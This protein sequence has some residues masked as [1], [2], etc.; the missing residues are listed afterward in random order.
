VT[1]TKQVAPAAVMAWLLGALIC[2]GSAGAAESALRVGPFIQS[3][4]G[5][6]ATVLWFGDAGEPGTVRYGLAA[7]RLD[8][9]ARSVVRPMP[10]DARP[11]VRFAH[12]AAL[13]G[14][15]AGKDVYYRV[16]DPEDPRGVARF[17]SDPGPKGTITFV[18]GG[19][20]VYLDPYLPFLKARG[21]RLDMALDLGDYQSKGARYGRPWW[22]EVPAYMAW[23]NHNEPD[24]E[25]HG[26]ALPGDKVSYTF[27]LGP[28]F[29]AMTA[30]A[31]PGGEQAAWKIAAE[32]YE[33]ISN[34]KQANNTEA[35][36]RFAAAGYALR[37]NGNDHSCARTYPVDG[38]RRDPEGTVF[39]THG[40]YHERTKVVNPNIST[41]YIYNAESVSLLPIITVSPERLEVRVRMHRAGEFLPKS[42][43]PEDWPAG[44]GAPRDYPHEWD[45][46]V[47]VKNPAYADRMLETLRAA[48]KA[49]RAD[50]KT[51]AAVRELGG[52]V[53]SR[54]VAPLVELLKMAKGARLRRE[55]AFALDRIG[56]PGA[57]P[58]M[59]TLAGDKDPMTRIAAAQFFAKF[60][61]EQDAKD[62]AAF[63]K[64]DQNPTGGHAPA[65]VCPQQYYVEGLM[66]R[67]GGPEARRLAPELLDVHPDYAATALLALARDESQER[68][69]AIRACVGRMLA[70][71]GSL[72]SL[73]APLADLLGPIT[74]GPGDL[75]RLVR[76]AE[77]FGARGG[78]KGVAQGLSRAGARQHVPLLVKGYRLVGPTG[79]R[80]IG[81]ASAIRSALEH[82]TDLG[83]PDPVVGAGRAAT[84]DRAKV[85]AGA[86]KAEEWARKHPGDDAAP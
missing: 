8:R 60:G 54:A 71:D 84:L 76:L 74:E 25:K 65:S 34:G 36:A 85:E 38:P 41:W 86:A 48:I 61:D 37:L 10:E 59:K 32:H 5:E 18:C 12:E 7:D 77:K 80:G 43:W 3:V 13:T 70:A 44:A 51:A 66:L 14:L 46:Y 9:T 58:V 55:I 31:A 81:D 78:W 42:E 53:E 40:G 64:D 82:L 2:A 39:L 21:I 52:L 24:S 49:G 73:A 69:P 27:T 17:R 50:D 56:D 6:K 19:D 35:A 62:L 22:R 11:K 28:A 16:T 15:P 79:R 20:E 26:W 57:M 33:I 67:I 1:K 75:A 45:Y 63:L 68:A 29:F 4:L 83:L 47:R 23:G 30:D 72:D